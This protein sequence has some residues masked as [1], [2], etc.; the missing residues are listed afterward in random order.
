LRRWRDDRRAVCG[1]GVVID[2]R[3]AARENPRSHMD[4]GCDAANST[5]I[6]ATAPSIRPERSH[7]LKNAVVASRSQAPKTPLP[8]VV[9]DIARGQHAWNARWMITSFSSTSVKPFSLPRAKWCVSCSVLPLVISAATV[10]TA[11]PLG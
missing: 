1:A 10:P 6:N 11:I 3:F 7:S 8:T 2:V 4:H 5:T 9:A